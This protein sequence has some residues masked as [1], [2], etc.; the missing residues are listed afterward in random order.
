MPAIRSQRA[1]PV[2][3]DG[4]EIETVEYGKRRV[5]FLELG[6]NQVQLTAYLDDIQ[7][8]QET[9]SNPSIP[10][11]YNWVGANLFPGEPLSADGKTI[12]V[13]DGHLYVSWHV[14]QRNPLDLRIMTSN[15][16]P[17]DNWW[18]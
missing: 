13:G 9:L 11:L 16:P 1:T 4:L 2:L 15:A 7:V 8:A 18:Q 5:A 3:A 12:N 6:G 10:D 17:P 14:V